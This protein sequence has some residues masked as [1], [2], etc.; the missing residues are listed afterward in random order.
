[1]M[2]LHYQQFFHYRSTP[3]IKIHSDK[4]L[5]G[6]GVHHKFNRSMSHGPRVEGINGVPSVFDSSDSEQSSGDGSSR[7][8]KSPYNSHD[9]FI[10]ALPS[11][12]KPKSPNTVF[13]IGQKD[14]HPDI[15]VKALQASL[16]EPAKSIDINT[17]THV[18]TV[19]DVQN[20]NQSD[21]SLL[22]ESRHESESDKIDPLQFV[23]DVT[24]LKRVQ[25]SFTDFQ[26][27]ASNKV[28]AAFRR[29]PLIEKA[30]SISSHDSDLTHQEQQV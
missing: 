18:E 10:H 25:A 6:P 7:S 22:R 28:A 29:P 30:S 20:S 26:E 12:R 11:D 9:H 14:D 23:E 19:Q 15:D 13:K 8:L 16:L 17:I 1:M 3:K 21:A 27:Q 4:L 5:D 2:L 24:S